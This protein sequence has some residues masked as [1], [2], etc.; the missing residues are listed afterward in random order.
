ME[1]AIVDLNG[2]NYVQFYTLLTPTENYV[3]KY[4]KWSSKYSN[5]ASLTKINVKKS[6]ETFHLRS[7]TSDQNKEQQNT[8]QS[9][10]SLLL[11][12]SII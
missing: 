11:Y 3:K 10:T 5:S 9:E 8:L 4:V 2:F 6:I 12:F 7:S 1:I